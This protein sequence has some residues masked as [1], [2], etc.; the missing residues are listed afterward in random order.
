MPMALMPTL[1]MGTPPRSFAADAHDRIMVRIPTGS[2]GYKAVARRSAPVGKLRLGQATPLSSGNR[3]APC[4]GLSTGR[5]NREDEKGG[6]IN[7]FTLDREIPIQGLLA[8]PV[9]S[10]PRRKSNPNIL[11]VPT[12]MTRCAIATTMT[13]LTRKVRV[14]ATACA[15]SKLRRS[16]KS[17]DFRATA[18]PSW[19]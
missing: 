1:R 4:I 18:I 17:R 6:G 3:R 10:C 7:R 13:Q 15:C 16:R 8:R 11:M 2:T 19:A 9:R 12:A 14:S 5:Q